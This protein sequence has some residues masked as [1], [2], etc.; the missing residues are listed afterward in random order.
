MG[1]WVDVPPAPRSPAEAAGAGRPQTE[2]AGEAMAARF[3]FK[4]GPINTGPAP[5]SP[6]PK[7]RRPCVPFVFAG[8]RIPKFDL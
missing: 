6:L 5:P 4:D 2:A 1:Q 7:I 8:E 3:K